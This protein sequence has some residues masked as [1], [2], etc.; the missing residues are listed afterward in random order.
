MFYWFTPCGIEIVRTY[1]DEG[2]SANYEYICRRAA[3][4]SLLQANGAT[5]IFL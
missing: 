5:A 4:P 3:L 1:A 2:K